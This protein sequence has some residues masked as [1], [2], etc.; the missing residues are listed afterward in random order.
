[1]AL[2]WAA[3]TPVAAQTRVHS[4][5]AIFV[6]GRRVESAAG[7]T[8]T[9]GGSI[10]HTL[11]RGETILDGTR[12]DVPAHV[13]VIIVSTGGKSSAT[14]QPGASITFVSTGLGE[15]VRINA[16]HAIFNVVPGTLAFFHVRY[17]EKLTMSAAMTTSISEA[18]ASCN[19]HAA[20]PST[21]RLRDCTRA[22]ILAGLGLAQYTAG[23][24]HR[25]FSSYERA[26]ALY[27]LVGDTRDEG[28][29]LESIGAVQ[30]REAEYDAAIASY[31]RALAFYQQI[32]DAASVTA[33][34]Q[35]IA[36]LSAL[37]QQ[38]PS[39]SPSPTISPTSSV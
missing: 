33:L 31:R 20:I 7:I 2:A 24:Y 27:Q 6:D 8:V 11:R 16:G 18:A 10:Q 3:A 4:V 39:A 28:R 29:S 1:M 37:M 34:E 13:E 17:G 26:F 35:D 23:R 14:L 12:V 36:R 32:G 38:T 5:Q 9:R 19:A 21:H 22:A 15:L 30:E 25:A